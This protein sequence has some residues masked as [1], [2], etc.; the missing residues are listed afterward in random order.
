MSVRLAKTQISLGIRPVGSVF[1]VR[2]KKAWVF[3]YPLSARQRLWSDW[4]DAQAHLSLRWAHSHFVG[5]VLSGLISRDNIFSAKLLS[6][7]I[8]A[9][10]RHKKTCLRGFRLGETQTSLLSYRDKLESWNFGFSK[11][12]YYTIEAAN[13]NGA[14]QTAQ[15]GRLI[16]T[17]VVR[18]WL[19]QVFSWCG[20]LYSKIISFEICNN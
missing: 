6:Y 11:Y 12:T 3:S 8:W 20:S 4:A 18:I 7:V 15:I 5:F 14:D 2:M 13:N 10:S 17:F 9:S 16:C 19:K 1:A